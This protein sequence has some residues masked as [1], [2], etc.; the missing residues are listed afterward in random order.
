MSKNNIIEISNL[1]RSFTEGERIQY[2]LRDLNMEVEKGEC[3]ILQGVSGSGKTTLLNLIAGI[4]RPNKGKISV[5]G[6]S[7]SKLSDRYLS[8]FRGQSIGMVFQHYHLIPHLSVAQN[9]S[10][11]LT[12]TNMTLSAQQKRVESV[13]NLVNIS[14][15]ATSS[16]AT[17]SGG[18]KQRASIARA[19][20]SDPNILLCDEPTANLDR[21]NT[22]TI[23][24]LFE[25]LH[26]MGKT[27]LI[28]THDPRF[29]SLPFAS[30]IVRMQQGEI[31]S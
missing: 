4:D 14:H 20:A 9:I 13:M 29:E 30:R 15:K 18:E 10:V 28:A 22:E 27:L 7:I 12:V 8:S 3:V 31:V 19:L 16:A 24:A 6:K 2:V 21:D 11:P 25:T 26:D 1:E 17:L 23:I 5:E